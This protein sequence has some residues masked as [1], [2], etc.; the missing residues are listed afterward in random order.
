MHILDEIEKLMMIF[1]HKFYKLLLIAGADSH[2]KSM[3]L[4]R[5]AEDSN[6]VY[7]NL[8]LAM[9]ERLM[10]IPVQ[11]RCLYITQYMDEIVQDIGTETILFD[12]IEILFEKPLKTNPLALLKNLSRH[13]KLI[14]AW[15]GIIKNNALIYAKPGHPEYVKYSIEV[16]YTVF[17]IDQNYRASF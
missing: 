7:I 9:A 2:K 4:K 6:H 16:D 10:M 5:L 13:R 17:D 15:P 11:E 8:N 12:H 14:T 1:P 3:I